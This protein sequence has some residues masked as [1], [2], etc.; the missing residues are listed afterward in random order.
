MS[1]NWGRLKGAGA[2]GSEVDFHFLLFLIEE[3]VSYHEIFRNEKISFLTKF[4]TILKLKNTYNYI[5][6][7]NL[8]RDSPK[9]NF[10][11]YLLLQFL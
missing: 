8:N 6:G 2:G 7:A 5:A 9:N 3:N 1:L 10:K 4:I 11:I